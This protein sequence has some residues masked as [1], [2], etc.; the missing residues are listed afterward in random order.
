MTYLNIDPAKR[1]RSMRIVQDQLKAQLANPETT[2]TK[3]T[4]IETRLTTLSGWVSGTLSVSTPP[5]VA[6]NVTPQTYPAPSTAGG[7]FTKFLPP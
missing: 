5:V 2:P 4:E 6:T 1:A 7:P 3:R